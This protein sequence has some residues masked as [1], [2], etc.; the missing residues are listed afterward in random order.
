MIGYQVTKVKMCHGCNKELPI[1][2]FSKNNYRKDGLQTRCKSCIR[3]Y[4]EKWILDN[5]EHH[6]KLIKKNYEENKEKYLIKQNEYKSKNKDKI[7]EMFKRY[8]SS[9][10]GREQ[11]LKHYKIYKKRNPEKTR[12]RWLVRTYLKRGKIVKK[13]CCNCGSESNI[14]AHHND[15]SKPLDIS[16]YCRSCHSELHRRINKDE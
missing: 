14:H 2:K 3:K 6:K 4:Q 15:Y 11:R 12:A 8:Y 13:P 1:E 7:K 16:W 5:S 10:I 9:E